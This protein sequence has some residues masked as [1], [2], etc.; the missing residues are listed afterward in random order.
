MKLYIKYMYSQDCQTLV[1]DELTKLG[2]Y[3]TTVGIGEAELISTISSDQILQLN[4]ALSS[5]GLQVQEG[6]R[7]ILVERIKDVVVEYI[8]LTREQLTVNFSDYLSVKLQY[9]YTYLANIFSKE[10]KTTIE[11]FIIAHKI[12]RAK[13]LIVQGEM[14]LTEIAS[15]LHYSSVS[16]FSNQFKRITGLTP[17]SFRK[18][19]LLQHLQVSD[20]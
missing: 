11:K 4:M 6:N 12:K 2:I 18:E 9:D 15:V 7:F 5:S 8:H 3:Y 1:K 19:M 10:E 14:K 13:K 16:H 17:S 20:S